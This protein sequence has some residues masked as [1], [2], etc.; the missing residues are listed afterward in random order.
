MH[1]GRLIFAQLIDFFPRYEFGRIQSR[2]RNQFRVRNFSCMDQFLCMTFAQLTSRHSLRDIET[3]LRAMEPKLYHVGLRGTVARST[4][5]DA[6]ER[7]PWRIWSELADVLL[8]RAR[9]LYANDELALELERSVYAFDASVIDLC[10]SLFPWATFR[11]SK[12]GVKLHTL[13]DLRGN[14]PITA[15]ITPASVHEVTLLDRLRIEPGALYLFDRGYLDFE[16]LHRIHRHGAWFVIRAKRNTKLQRLYS[17]PVDRTVGLRCDQTVTLGGFYAREDYPDHLRRIRFVDPDQGRD[18]VFLTNEF[19]LP[20]MTIAELY[21]QRWQVELFFKWIK[22]HLR[23][24]AFY[25]VT[26]NAVKTQIWIAIA[27][28]VMVAIVKKELRLESSLYTILQVLGIA[29]FEKMPLLRALSQ[30]DLSLQIDP[31]CEQLT[32]FDL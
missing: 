32:P 20:A 21:R 29:L 9:C 7:R 5:A 31:S 19:N 28:Y 3:C 18:L 12:A 16:R 4:L 10:L 13:L 8:V 11:K 26:E 6:N 14:L 22:Q 17:R 2:Y 1:Q 30:P 23:I 27:V 24:Q 15:F 25:G